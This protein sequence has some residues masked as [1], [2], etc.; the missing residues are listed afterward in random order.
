MLIVRFVRDP[1]YRE[2]QRDALSGRVLRRMKYVSVPGSV[3]ADGCIERDD[4]L[5]IESGGRRLRAWARRRNGEKS[6]NRQSTNAAS[7]RIVPGYYVVSIP[8][9]VV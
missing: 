2:P 5:R 4:V 7:F 1:A 3:P 8:E 6:A 9:V